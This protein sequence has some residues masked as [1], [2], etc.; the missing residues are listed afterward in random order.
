MF[1]LSDT[2]RLRGG[3][4]G[5]LL[6]GCLAFSSVARAADPGPIV[7]RSVADQPLQ[8]EVG[9]SLRPDE[10]VEDIKVDV[11][12]S[13]EYGWLEV[14]RPGWAD[15]V[16]I[17]VE[18]AEGKPR[19]IL[20]TTEP[21][22]DRRFSLLLVV[23]SPAGRSL[24]Q[25]DV[26][27]RDAD[28]LSVPA[29]LPKEPDAVATPP[30]EPQDGAPAEAEPPPAAE[31][32]PVMRPS[33]Q[34]ASLPE[35]GPPQ[36]RRNLSISSSGSRLAAS[37]FEKRAQRLEESA[38]VQ[39][40]ALEEANSRIADL[41]GQ[42][43]KLQSLL[44]LKGAAPSPGTPQGGKPEAVPASPAAASIA[45]KPAGAGG[46]GAVPAPAEPA[47]PSPPPG[48]PATMTDVTPIEAVAPQADA[49]P[50]EGTAEEAPAPQPAEPAKPAPTA[51]AAPAEDDIGSLLVVVGASVAVLLA[52]TAGALWWRRRR[53]RRQAMLEAAASASGLTAA[54]GSLPEDGDIEPGDIGVS[55]ATPA[56]AQAAGP[57]DEA[58]DEAF[59][60]AFDEPLGDDFEPEQAPQAS[61]A[62]MIPVADLESLSAEP[63]RPAASASAAA[64]DD[65]DALF[66]E[67]AI[68]TAQAAIEAEVAGLAPDAT[69]VEAA[70]PPPEPA[71]PEVAASPAEGE[72]DEDDEAADMEDVE[73]NLAKAYIDMGDPDGARAILE[74]MMA[75]G[76][77]PE[78]AAL[79][80]RT[81][82]RFGLQS[83]PPP[84]DA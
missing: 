44:A 8:A 79:A 82:R 5:A 65:L 28:V 80:Q 84:A 70:P 81:M 37:A 49:Q 31:S 54:V 17:A 76:D 73:V 15:D 21:P 40:R 29:A 42:V 63:Q 10:T 1:V 3:L 58:V 24:R 39:R 55:D 78:R 46:K 48:A 47:T 26:V 33:R 35:R 45:G 61:P 32:L 56:E 52:A 7:I 53:A 16:G 22:P 27:L 69:A 60:A 66:S 36:V 57:V 9:L 64:P 25:Y 18:E 14:E 62:G 30:I 68:A 38:A 23:T 11:G 6:C 43:E 67:E 51:E 41:Q 12:G 19:V 13:S 77:N 59:A 2:L 74:G 50:A 34:V 75:D 4:F 83:D 20:W 71:Q 72:A